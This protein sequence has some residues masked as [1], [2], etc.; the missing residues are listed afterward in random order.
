MI[1]EPGHPDQ[2]GLLNSVCGTPRE[3][4]LRAGR[5][6]VRVQAFAAR[7]GAAALTSMAAEALG[8][9]FVL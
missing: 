7:S 2:V 6:V 5:L 1:L 9:R 8:N 4:P 3:G